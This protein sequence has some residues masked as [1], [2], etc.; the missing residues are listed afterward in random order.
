MKC[1]LLVLTG[2]RIRTVNHTTNRK[3]G[4]GKKEG[5]SPYRLQAVVITRR[6]WR[7]GFYARD[8][9][10]CIEVLGVFVGAVVM[11]IRGQEVCNV[12]CDNPGG[13][14]KLNSIR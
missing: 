5:G 13:I 2:G 6:L 4:V 11:F 8:Y 12:D 9:L 7:D 3:R 10:A 14:N 1:V